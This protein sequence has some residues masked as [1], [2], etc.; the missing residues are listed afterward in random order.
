MTFESL[1]PAETGS[2][3]ACIV[4]TGSLPAPFAGRNGITDEPPLGPAS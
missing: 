3:P 1:R 2:C 4:M